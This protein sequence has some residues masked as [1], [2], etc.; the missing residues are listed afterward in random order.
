MPPDY[1][2][3]ADRI[4]QYWQPTV[5]RRSENTSNAPPSMSLVVP[6]DCAEGAMIAK[7]VG[8]Q[9]T[10][11]TETYV[12]RPTPSVKFAAY[13]NI[14]GYPSGVPLSPGSATQGL[15]QADF[16][17]TTTSETL[18]PYDIESFLVGRNSESSFSEASNGIDEAPPTVDDPR[19]AIEGL[20][21]AN[22]DTLDPTKP[23]LSIFEALG[24][25][26]MVRGREDHFMNGFPEG[27]GNELYPP[28]LIGSI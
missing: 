27:F 20:V 23:A 8:S 22:Y 4:T 10:F 3:L 24:G 18:H 7:Q 13:S 12:D 17:I 11:K 15:G 21:Y 1:L 6:H 2:V 16:I 25:E 26:M 5:V 9:T 19:G 28:V 14:R